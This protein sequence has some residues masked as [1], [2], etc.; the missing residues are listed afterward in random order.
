MPYKTD[1]TWI[2]AN[3]FLALSGFHRIYLVR[4]KKEAEKWL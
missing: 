1:L 4:L 2:F 3:L